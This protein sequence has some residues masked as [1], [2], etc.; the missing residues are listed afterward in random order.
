MK[1]HWC[2]KT[3][4]VYDLEDIELPLGAQPAGSPQ[5]QHDSSGRGCWLVGYWDTFNVGSHT[6]APPLPADGVQSDRIED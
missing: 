6:D 2:Y 1:R 4:M 5:Y 3:M